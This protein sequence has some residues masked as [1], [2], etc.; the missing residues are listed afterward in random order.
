MFEKASMKTN[1]P[2]KAQLIAHGAGS[3]TDR[4]LIE[5]F[6][7]PKY[8]LMLD[9]LMRQYPNLN[10]LEQLSVEELALFDGIGMNKAT[11]ILAAIELGKRILHQ[12]YTR[13]ETVTSSEALGKGLIKY[14]LGVP[15]EYLIGFYMDVKNRVIQRQLLSIGSMTASL[16]DPKLIYRHSLLLKAPRLIL[17]H[18]HPSG[19]EK[20]SEVDVKVTTQLVQAAQIMGIELVDHLIVGENQYYSFREAGKL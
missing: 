8:Q 11:N 17:A 9:S 2:A 4:Q 7:G 12:Q 10:G 19:S 15:Q 5:V 18:N 6:V 16:V 13:V 20:P 3:L 1:Q 14:F